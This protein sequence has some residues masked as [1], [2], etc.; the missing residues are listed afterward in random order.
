LFGRLLSHVR[1]KVAVAPSIAAPD[2]QPYA[3]F[4][5]N[6]G[7]VRFERL[8]LLGAVVPRAGLVEGST[9]ECRSARQ[10]LLYQRAQDVLL[11]QA[12]A[13][14]GD[15]DCEV[16]LMKNNC[17]GHGSRFGSHENYEAE[18][19]AG[20]AFRLWRVGLVAVVLPT[21]FAMELF[22]GLVLVLSVA[23]YFPARLAARL[24]DRFVRLWE[25]GTL[26]LISV[27]LAPVM[28]PATVLFRLLAFRRQRRQMLAFLVTR[29]VFAGAGTVGRNGQLSMSPR[30][31]RVGSVVGSIAEVSG[32]VFL[33]GHVLKAADHV[34]AGDT[35]RYAA[36][37]RRRQRLQIAVGDSNMAPVAEFLKIGTTLLVLDAIE[38]GELDDAPRLRRPL[39]ALRTICRDLDLKA[40]V[41]LRG[42]RRL[43]AVDV[44]KFYWS[45]CR[46]YVERHR[47]DDAEAEEALTLWAETLDHLEHD[48]R[49]L[50]GRVDWVTKRMLLEAPQGPL[51]VDARRKLDRRYH[52]LSRNGSYLRLEAAGATATVVE[53]EDVLAAIQNPPTGTRA[54][55]RGRLIR[56][57]ARKPG[58]IRA[59]WTTV[60]LRNGSGQK[61]VSLD[62]SE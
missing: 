14:S 23:L 17:D 38:A 37:F 42:G 48:P 45:A 56:E 9:P 40:T 51:S 25:W 39:R 5:A 26:A 41:T 29:Q 4:T 3:W 46:R 28:F 49:R 57:F 44:Q 43:T 34:F 20:W 50:F 11:S 16:A 62:D 55:V 19:A 6:G 1:G 32:P 52:E 10:F 54:A 12:A 8:P 59:G 22:G 2:Q 24:S 53:P 18:V 27:V 15:A 21:A 31:Q 36:L 60:V 58:G 35:S 47:P 13:S 30:V 7:S 33:F 61:T